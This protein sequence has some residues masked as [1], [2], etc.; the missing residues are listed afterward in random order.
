MLCSRRIVILVSVAVAGIGFVCPGVRAATSADL[1]TRPSAD[2]AGPEPSSTQL[3]PQTVTPEPSCPA[4]MLL[5]PAAAV[6][7]AAETFAVP[8]PAAGGP[9][10]KRSWP[11]NLHAPGAGFPYTPTL[12]DCD[13]D[14]AD[15]IFLTGG[16][17]F[18]LRGDGTFLP[19]WP[20]TEHIYMGYGTND[21]KPGPSCADVDGDGD[22]EIMWSERDWYAGSAHMW[23]F[24][25]RNFDGSN[26]PNFP[27]VAPGDYSNAL[28][29][30]FVLGDTDGDG[31]L[32][33]W[34]PHTLGN[35][36]VHYRISAFDHLGNRLF[37][38]DLEA[39]ENTLSL[40]F[41]DL[42]GNGAAEMFAMA[43][44]GQALRLHAFDANGNEQA[45]Y[46][47]TLYT[48]AGETLPFG[49]PIVADLDGDGDLEILFGAWTS[50]AT[51]VRAYHHDGAPCTGFPIQIAT[52]HQLFYIGLGDLTGDGVPELL[53]TGKI[54]SSD[55][56]VHAVDLATGTVLPGW[57][58]ALPYWPEGFPTVA[59]VDNDGYQEVCISTG[60]GDVRVISRTGQLLPG[61]PLPMVAA[62]ISGV[63]VGDIDGD[64]LFEMVA[65]TWDGWVYAWDTPGEALFGRADWPMRN[66]NERNTGVF[67][68]H[69]ASASVAALDAVRRW[70]L[71][72]E[73]NPFFGSA[74]FRIAPTGQ[75]LTAQTGA[76][77]PAV[78]IYSAS[79]R[80]VEVLAA[81]GRSVASWS[82]AQGTAAGV[83]YARLRGTGP[84]EAVPIVLVR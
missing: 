60:G 26:M 18:G 4:E 74:Q 33:A 52:G 31:D 73:P 51:R 81:G 69:G 44:L 38:R 37:T 41:G 20:T 72:V 55:Y 56:R 53:A 22:V 57:P 29:V 62:A 79:G 11:V 50:G 5:A 78:E 63:A 76:G 36:F 68:D 43:A 8:A 15:E 61:Y 64:G 1:A 77:A 39:T 12:F 3:A 24:N 58:Y 32:E 75:P 25:G 47:R 14:G 13:H 71:S 16:N 82:P 27:Q 23:C 48:L 42:D 59:D 6:A 80:L 83:Y 45:G 46:P 2:L 30:P 65:A 40:Y 17:T 70:K 7:P 84:A 67:G 28:D 49:P 35:N 34:S 19:G 10:L 21:Q 9:G 54:L 66:I